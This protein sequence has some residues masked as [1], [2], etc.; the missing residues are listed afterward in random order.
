MKQ[1][2]AGKIT[3]WAELLRIHD[4][5]QRSKTT[6][7]C[8]QSYA[9]QHSQEEWSFRNPYLPLLI[10]VNTS[11]WLNTIT[12]CFNQL[13]SKSFSQS[14]EP[15]ELWLPNKLWMFKED[16]TVN[17]NPSDH[18]VITAVYLQK[19]RQS[20]LCVCTSKHFINM[21]LISTACTSVLKGLTQHVHAD[22]CSNAHTHRRQRSQILYII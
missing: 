15:Q 10:C 17:F 22:I 8:I 16:N 13:S 2:W 4:P 20:G 6:W 18:L 12:S 7:I 5:Q 9:A 14:S 3:F 11:A 21:L 19:K 1:K